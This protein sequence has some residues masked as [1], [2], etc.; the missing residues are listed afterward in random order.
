MYEIIEVKG[1]NRID[2]AEVKAKGDAALEIA[3]ESAMRYKIY[4]S[5]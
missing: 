5:S 1:D 4:K 3:K 2:D